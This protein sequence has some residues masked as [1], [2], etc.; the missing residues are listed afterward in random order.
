MCVHDECFSGGWQAGYSSEYVDHC[1]PRRMEADQDRRGWPGENLVARS[2]EMGYPMIFVAMNYRLSGISSYMCMV[3]ILVTKVLYSAWFPR[4][5]GS[6][7][8][9]SC[10]LRPL[11]SYVTA[12]DLCILASRR[13]L[14]KSEIERVALQWVNKYISGFGGDPEKVMM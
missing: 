2:I 14:I 5:E 10:E 13:M 7:R 6:Q 4:R 11:R 8:R 12:Y 1:S 3:P 9:R